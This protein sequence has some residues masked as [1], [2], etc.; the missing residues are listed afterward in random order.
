[1]PDLL[2]AC[3]GAPTAVINASL[4]GV[5]WQSKAHPEITKIW[6]AEHGVQGILRERLIDLSALSKAEEKNLLMSPASAIGTSRTPLEPSDYA[7]MAAI[8]H[9]RGI[10]YVLLNGGNGTMDTCGRLAKACEA[11]GIRC[12]GIPKTIDNDIAVIDHAPGF[13]SAARF[14]ALSA[15]HAAMDVMSLPIHVC[16]LE[17]MGR[18]AGWLAASAALARKLTPGWPHLIYLPERPF[19]TERFLQD[20]KVMHEKHGGVLVVVSEGLADQNGQSPV[21]PLYTS[22]RATYPGDIGQHLAKLV[23]ERLHIKARSEKPGILGRASAW[24]P[25]DVDEAIL[26]GREAVKL[27]VQGQTHKMAGL[28]R[29]PGE[30]Y[31][32]QV[33]AVPI[34]EVMLNERK[35]PD[36]YIHPSGHDVTQAFIDW[37]AP[38]VGPLPAP[39]L[40]LGGR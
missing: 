31:A 2:I 7:K 23:I 1:M 9:R 36:E 21:P 5:L 28:F 39:Y 18:N 40:F 8:L 20:V 30:A 37:C 22:G 29:E 24:S 4:Y 32:A 38:L 34:E 17:T 6:G 16:I 35:M 12:V 33:R 15:A 10:G 19:D 26:V 3:G 11:Y 13:G 25:V 14:V 27:A